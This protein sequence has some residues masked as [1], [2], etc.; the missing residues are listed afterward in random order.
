MRLKMQG[1]R[2]FSSCN[3]SVDVPIL[4]C[5]LLQYFS[6]SYDKHNMYYVNAL[7]SLFLTGCALTQIALMQELTYPQL[8]KRAVMNL[9]LYLHRLQHS[10]EI[11]VILF[12]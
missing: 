8:K 2:T 12:I 7:I 5:L 4:L 11:K 3:I 10:Q 1:K 6:C 9:Q